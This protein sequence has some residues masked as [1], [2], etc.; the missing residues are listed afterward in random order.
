MRFA[1]WR[2][3]T[4]ALNIVTGASKT[5]KSA[6]IDIIDYVTGRSEC[7]VADGVIRKYVGWYALLFQL[8]HGHLFV[9]RRNPEVGERTS[10]DVYMDRGSSR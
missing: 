2:F 5:G 7:N 4:G 9:A 3:G 6:I 1:S 8:N 10:G